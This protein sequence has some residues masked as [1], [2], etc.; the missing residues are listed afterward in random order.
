MHWVSCIMWLWLSMGISIK[1]LDQNG[2]LQ[3]IDTMCVD[4]NSITL[5][6]LVFELSALGKNYV[7]AIFR[8]K[9]MLG[10]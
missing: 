4:Q 3:L 1:V 7:W 6:L 8:V 5:A 2:C 9:H 10:T